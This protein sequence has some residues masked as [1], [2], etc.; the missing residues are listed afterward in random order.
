LFKE[1]CQ[2]AN[3]ANSILKGSNSNLAEDG[4]SVM[5]HHPKLEG[6]KALVTGASRGI[7][8]QIA[9]ALASEGADVAIN[10]SKSEKDADEVAKYVEDIGSESWVYP[11]DIGNYD[12]VVEMKESITKYFGKIDILV[13]NA[14]INIDKLFVK[15]TNEDWNRVITINLT[16]VFNCTN[17]FIDQLIESEHGRIINITSI[18][19]QM[20]NIGQVNYAASKAGIIGMTKS[21]ARE[22]ARKNVT[23]NAVAPGFILTSMVKNI[24]EE[25]KEKIIK[26]IPLGRFGEPEEVARAV[27]YLASDDAAYITGHVLNINGG[28]YL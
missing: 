2:L 14:G 3:D 26:Q 7:G 10:Y 9:F 12:N 18:V 17:A 27:I 22:L 20:G 16:G 23:V 1:E 15:M 19:G 6:R 24:P 13:N 21:L 28:M 8:K 25:V 5:D 11:A 4:G